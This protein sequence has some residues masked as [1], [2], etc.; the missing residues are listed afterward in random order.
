M[1]VRPNMGVRLQN[2]L[3]NTELVEGSGWARG[4]DENLVL[5]FQLTYYIIWTLSLG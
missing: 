1:Y 3:N 5:Y 4:P 2:K